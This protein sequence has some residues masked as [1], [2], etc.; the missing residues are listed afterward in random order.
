MSAARSFPLFLVLLSVALALISQPD[1]AGDIRRV[2]GLQAQAGSLTQRD[3]VPAG[4]V[5]APYYPAPPGGWVSSWAAAY[6]KAEKVVANMTL[7]EKVNLT[8]GTGELM[9][10]CVGNTGSAMRFGIPNLCLQDSALGVAATDSRPIT[11]S[12]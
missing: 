3:A 8:T 1:F 2:R 6:A 5:A 11:A 12:L 4:Y 9:G 7:A 10:P